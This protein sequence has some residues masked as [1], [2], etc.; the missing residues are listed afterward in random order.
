[1]VPTLLDGLYIDYFGQ[2]TYYYW[3]WS[4]IGSL[5]VSNPYDQA[6]P[7]VIGFEYF[8]DLDMSANAGVIAS[9]YANAGL[10]GVALY[11]MLAGLLLALLNAFG[12]RIGHAFVA[13]A[14]LMTFHTILTTADLL[15]AILSHGVL[16]LLMM[17][18]L[19]PSAAPQPAPRPQLQPA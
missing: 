14:S 6:A 5:F 18:V 7:F 11:S 16:L 3:S 4:R 9:G 1:M 8:S 2:R 15:T 12:R 13:A 10:P 19:F 17:L